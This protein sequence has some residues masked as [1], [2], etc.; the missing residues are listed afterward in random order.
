MIIGEHSYIGNAFNLYC[1]KKEDCNFQIDKVGAVNRDW[2]K[3]DFQTYDVVFLV[4]AIVHKKEKK[5]LYYKINRDMA[6]T[7]AEKAKI[8]GVKQFIFLST[9]A[10]FGTKAEKI[11]KN[12]RPNPDTFYGASKLKAEEELFTMSDKTFIVTVVRPPMVYGYNCPGNFSKLKKIAKY[13]VLFPEI[14]N[15]RSMIY[16]ETLCAYIEK[17][18]NQPKTEVYHIQNNQYVSTMKL[19]SEIRKAYGKYTYYIPGFEKL[20]RCISKKINIFQKI[21]GNCYYDEALL[22]NLKSDIAIESEIDFLESVRRSVLE[23]KKFF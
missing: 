23:T 6:I 1:L 7:I 8:S 22:E 20:I 11:T 17:M 15:Y 2:E 16:I 9:M 10:V 18:I 14:K 5:E 4:A 12:M 13:T 19:F 3:C 21:F